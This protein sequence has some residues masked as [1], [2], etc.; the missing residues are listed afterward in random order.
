[1]TKKTKGKE[2]QLSR[3]E[4]LRDAGLVVGGATAVAMP[5]LAACDSPTT[6][7]T[8]ATATTTVTV[9]TAPITTVTTI[10][11]TTV[12]VTAPPTVDPPATASA[13]STIELTVNGLKR[14]VQI[15]PHQTLADMLR[16]TLGLTGTKVGCDRGACGAC[17]VLVNGKPVLACMMLAIEAGETSVTT[18]EGLAVKGELSPLQ[19]AVYDHTGYQCGFCTPGLIMEATALL[20]EKPQPTME[21]MKAAFGGHIC[22]CGA[23][24]SFMES[25]TL[26]GGK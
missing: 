26:A 16:D 15:E 20:A 10:P 23:Y 22:R 6:A 21:E 11:T 14:L 4:F 5:L 18:I 17:T 1:M 9:T 19:Q 2:G 3:R 12:T 8:T 25:V 24:Y 7:T 13:I